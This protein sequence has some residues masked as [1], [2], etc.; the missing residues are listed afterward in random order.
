MCKC[1]TPP[2]LELVNAV[3]EDDL[4]ALVDDTVHDACHGED[5]SDDTTHRNEELNDVLARI[6]VL[7]SEGRYLVIENDE[8]LEGLEFGLTRRCQ[9]EYLP[10]VHQAVAVENLE[11]PSGKLTEEDRWHRFDIETDSHRRLIIRFNPLE[12]VKRMHDSSLWEVSRDRVEICK[13]AERQM[14]DLEGVIELD[15]LHVEVHL[16]VL[17]SVMTNV[18]VARNAQSLDIAMNLAALALL[19]LLLDALKCLFTTRLLLLISL[20]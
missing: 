6:S 13:F 18:E 14:V 5:T 9:L 2:S 11:D 3:F 15:P 4:A 19:K 20:G 12:A 8:A 17:E 10:E 7:H 16:N 1:F